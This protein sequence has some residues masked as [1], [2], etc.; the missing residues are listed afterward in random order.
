[1][2][3]I[4]SSA[5]IAILLNEPTAQLLAERISNEVDGR[6][7]LSAPNYVETGTVLATRRGDGLR[8]IQILNEFLQDV[9]IEVAPIDWA[10]SQMALE[11]RIKFGRGFGARAQLNFGDSFAYA[12]AKHLDAPLLF[13]GDDFTHTDVRSALP[14]TS[15]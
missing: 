11:A 14:V 7:R 4:D 13:I 12:L 8:A 10:L 3:V 1:M 6:Y 9:G 15:R 5:I 2:L